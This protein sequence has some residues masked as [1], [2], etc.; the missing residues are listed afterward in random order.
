MSH[1]AHSRAGPSRHLGRYPHEGTL[2]A[3]YLRGL[4]D[5]MTGRPERS[6]TDTS[7]E[8]RDLDPSYRK[9]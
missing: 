6:L 3:A 5:L 8:T 1:I 9:R 4:T 2:A 7:A